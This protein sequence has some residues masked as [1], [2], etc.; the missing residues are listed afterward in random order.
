LLDIMYEIPSSKQIR[1]CVISA[2][3]IEGDADP[4]LYDEVGRPIKGDD[5]Q[6]HKAA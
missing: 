4:E 3:V 2:A 6:Q 1:K 5:L